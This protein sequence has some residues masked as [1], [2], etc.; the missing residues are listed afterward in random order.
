MK[1]KNL[2]EKFDDS[3]YKGFGLVSLEQ[4]LAVIATDVRAS[5]VAN[6]VLPLEGSDTMFRAFEITPL[7][8]VKVV[9]LGQDPYHDGSFNGLAFGNGDWL[10][11]SPNAIGRS[12]M[13]EPYADKTSPSLRKIVLEVEK[14]FP[15]EVDRS[16][17]AWARQGVLLINTAHTVIAKEAGSHLDIWESFTHM[18]LKAINTVPNVV[19]LLWGAKA[20]AFEH[21]ILNDTH[22]IILS[23]HPSPLNRSNPFSG[24]CFV[25]CNNKLK[26]MGKPPIKWTGQ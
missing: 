17:Y 19:W 4:K 11:D 16:L 25:D 26:E 14:Q 10:D 15:G 8:E 21:E 24:D 12:I 7:D 23:G 18:I 13:E 6:K 20:H 3:W 5:R 1:K 9:I 2:I 22:H